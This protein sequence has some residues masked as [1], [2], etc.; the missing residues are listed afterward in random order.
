MSAMYQ[1]IIG[2]ICSFA[3]VSCSVTASAVKEQGFYPS[4]A[5]VCD[6]ELRVSAQGGFLQLFVQTGNGEPIHVA[7]DV[8][9]F[10]WID[11]NTMVFSASPVYGKPGIFEVACAADAG[12]PR[13][14]TLV[15]PKNFNA[16][17]PD[18]VD[19][20]ELRG[21]KGDNI[22]FY[23]A[24]DVDSIDFSRFRSEEHLNSVRLTKNEK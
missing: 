24:A 15:A 22:E 21:I 6:A 3:L 13:S 14:T 11:G 8:T 12:R 16:A 9:A 4:P 23:Y 19:Y 1:A 5:K 18:G 7:D 2:V 20:F 10:M 17:Y